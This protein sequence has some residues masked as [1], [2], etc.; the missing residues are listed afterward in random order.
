MRVRFPLL[1]GVILGSLIACVAQAAALSPEARRAAQDLLETRQ[2]ST[3]FASM[4]A[5]RMAEAARVRERAASRAA[6]AAASAGRRPARSS[7]E[8]ASAFAA[9]VRVND[10][11]TDLFSD[12]GQA[13]PSVAAIGNQAVVV[14]KDGDG[15]DEPPPASQQQLLGFGY[16]TDGGASWTDGGALPQRPGLPDWQWID[17][18]V[19]VANDS[20]GEW[21]AAGL[22]YPNG[23]PG[24]GSVL[25]VAVVKGTFTGSTFAWGVPVVVVSYL[26]TQAIVDRPWLAVDRGTGNVYLTFTRNAL[27]S[28]L[29]DI[30][31]TSSV[32]GLTWSFLTAISSSGDSHNVQGSRVA[33]GPNGEVYVVWQTFGLV[34]DLYKIRKSVN[35]GTS[36]G[37]EAVAAFASSNPTTQPGSNERLATNYPR[38]AVDRTASPARG[39]V[40]LGW[41]ETVDYRTADLAHATTGNVNEAEGSGVFGQNDNATR[42]VPFTPGSMLRG[43][44]ADVDNDVDWYK[45]SATFGQM[46][47]FY[48]D[49]LSTGLDM[50]FRVMCTDSLT[51]CALAS[52]G[53][54]A[55][56]L[57]VWSAPATGTYYLRCAAWPLSSDPG[58]HRYR[59]RTVL[60]TDPGDD[61][62]RDTRD[63]FVASSADGV[64]W[65]FSGAGSPVRV[66]DDL[67]RY[68]DVMPEIAVTAGGRVLCTWYDWRDA[69]PARCAGESNLYLYRSEDQGASWASLGMLTDATSAWSTASTNL[70]PNEGDY[71]G[72]FASEG[73]VYAA[74]TDARDGNPNIYSL[75]IDV[76]TPTL[77]ALAGSR[78]APD[79]VELDWL[80][81]D[82]ASRTVTL[83]RRDDSGEWRALE[84]RIVGPD[85]RVSFVDASVKAGARYAYRLAATSGGLVT[86]SS[87]AEIVVP[88]GLALSLGAPRPNPASGPLT[89]TVTLPDA[90]PATLTLVDVAGRVIAAREVGTLGPGVH[91][92]A[93]GAP[94]LA[95]GVYVARLQSRDRTLTARAIAVR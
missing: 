72:L 37:S 78:V 7:F 90:A 5:Y 11:S 87:E 89:F 60:H 31:F 17:D 54:G 19:V 67:S 38:I 3:S 51:K 41:A 68:D 85:G 23:P 49:S 65:P 88:R 56:D 95:P 20:T 75:P 48:V 22:V 9:N 27:T 71:L 47:V 36:F 32:D 70:V 46:F 83:Q 25:G 81:L 30:R 93:L 40:Y 16:T 15:L 86:Y 26:T 61:R 2:R 18:P 4:F 74:W 58:P 84:D 69:D 64:T 35:G 73:N 42:A 79:R 12:A 1:A 24:T 34:L 92:V 14:W 29:E 44:I 10:P 63:V 21:W 50:D 57:I 45:F 77:A 13:T 33:V 91:A 8:H 94:H 28:N 80:A 52:A 66:N 59:I 76:T 82:W 39:R 53:K 43:S 6:R 62:G 55:K